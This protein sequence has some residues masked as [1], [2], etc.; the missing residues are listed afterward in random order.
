MIC[1]NQNLC[2]LLLGVAVIFGGFGITVLSVY[3]GNIN[4]EGGSILDKVGVL[5]MVL[6]A[7]SASR[8]LS[9]IDMCDKKPS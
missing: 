2:S 4:E 5:A 6:G 9:K 3:A 8:W 1:N 7:I